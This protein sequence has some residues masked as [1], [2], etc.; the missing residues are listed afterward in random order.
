MTVG[1]IEIFP[2]IIT[3]NILANPTNG[4]AMLPESVK[5]IIDVIGIIEAEKLIK[6]HGGTT[7]FFSSEMK[8]NINIS[9]IA[10]DKLMT[11]FNGNYVYI[12]KCEKMIKDRRNEQIKHERRSGEPINQLCRK[13]NLTDRRI[14]A[15]CSTPEIMSNYNQDDLFNN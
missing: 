8:V 10:K 3:Q 11:A 1:K 14:F 7:L 5:E 4:I 2:I 13:Y 15:I 9:D 12:P 6:Q